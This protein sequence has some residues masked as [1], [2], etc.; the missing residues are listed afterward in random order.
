MNTT[1]LRVTPKLIQLIHFIV[2][3]PCTI[4][5]FL[6]VM[7]LIQSTINHFKQVDLDLLFPVFVKDETNINTVPIELVRT[8]K[9]D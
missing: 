3:V 2:H 5:I 7:D 6:S 9:H 8:Y 1:Y 4:H